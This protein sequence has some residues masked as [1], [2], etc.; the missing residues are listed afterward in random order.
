MA[1]S[2]LPL[3]DRFAAAPADTLLP[4]V[5]QELGPVPHR[6]VAARAHEQDVRERQRALALDDAALPDLRRRPLV[7]LQHVQL[8]DD[9][10]LLVVEHAQHL[11]ALA[12][13]LARDHA[14]EVAAPDV[15][16]RHQ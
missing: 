3:V 2:S 5:G 12:S 6:A 7:L 8:L 9:D 15:R 10:A 4:A 11:A 14:Y 16:R 1:L 13:L